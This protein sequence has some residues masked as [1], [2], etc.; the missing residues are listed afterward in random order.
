[1]ARLS[2]A[3][4]KLQSDHD[5]ELDGVVLEND[6][7]ARAVGG[8]IVN[9]LSDRIAPKSDQMLDEEQCEHNYWNVDVPFCNEVTRKRGREAGGRCHHTA[10]I[11]FAFC[12]SG[13][14]IDALP[15]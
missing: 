2:G 15:P 3:I 13:K 1:M 7:T 10:L 14:P 8:A 11:R 6:P 9:S 4:Q 12:L 5:L